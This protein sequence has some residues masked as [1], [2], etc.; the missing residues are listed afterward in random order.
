MGLLTSTGLAE[1]GGQFLEVGGGGVECI[2]AL[3]F[4]TERDLQQLRRGK[5]APLQLFVKVVGEIHLYSRHTPE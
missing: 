4:G 5:P 3:E 1:F 2:L